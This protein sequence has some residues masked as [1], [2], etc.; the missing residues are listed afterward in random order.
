[1]LVLAAAFSFGVIV[2][3]AMAVH[4]HTTACGTGHGMVHGTSTT[5]GKFHARVDRGG[6]PATHKGCVAYYVPTT[7]VLASE[8]TTTA[9]CDAYYGGGAY[10]EYQE[11]AYV[12]YDT[13]F[14]GHSHYHH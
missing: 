5:D 3:A 2:R 4:F 13:V 9:N 7:T 10:S 12:T 6:C 8:Q 11:A 14:S 1:V